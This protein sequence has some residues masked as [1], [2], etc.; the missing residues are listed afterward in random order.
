MSKVFSQRNVGV[1]SAEIVL[2]FRVIVV[3]SAKAGV[4]SMNTCLCLSL[5]LGFSL[6]LGL[7]LNFNLG[8]SLGFNLCF[9]FSL[10]LGLDLSV[11]LCRKDSG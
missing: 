7:S 3:K 11:S 4:I 8:L 10:G 2:S 5:S 1:M 6:S 9:S